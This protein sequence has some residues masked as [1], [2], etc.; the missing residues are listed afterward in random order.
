MPDFLNRHYK[1]VS[2]GV[3]VVAAWITFLIPPGEKIRQWLGGNLSE[4]AGWLGVLVLLW[5][6]KFEKDW[7]KELKSELSPKVNENEKRIKQLWNVFRE[8]ATDAQLEKE[9]REILTLYPSVVLQQKDDKIREKVQESITAV[10]DILQLREY[11]VYFD[12]MAK[13]YPGPFYESAKK[14][15]IATNIGGPRNFWRDRGRLVEMNKK[16]VDRIQSPCRE[17]ENA[18]R[19]VFIIEK[20]TEKEEI[21]DLKQLMDELRG[22]G[23]VIRYLGF[24]RAQ[25]LVDNPKISLI[26]RLEDFTVFDTVNENLKYA[27]RFQDPKA[28]YKKVIISSD[29]RMIKSLT[30]HFEVLWEASAEFQGEIEPLYQL[31]RGQG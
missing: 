12:A 3:V 10:R 24:K 13:V 16:A 2:M 6:W 8:H 25:E 21:D 18:I 26:T 19:R 28:N 20:D 17:G 27:G 4:V 15:I 30:R 9:I 11:V 7:K 5:L 1:L 22:A 14:S 31:G 23:V 29:P